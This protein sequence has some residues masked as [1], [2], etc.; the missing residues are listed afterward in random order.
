[1][2]I[3]ESSKVIRKVLLTPLLNQGLQ[4]LSLDIMLWMVIRR[5]FIASIVENTFSIT[6]GYFYV[7]YWNLIYLKNCNGGLHLKIKG[8]S[9]GGNLSSRS[10]LSITPFCFLAK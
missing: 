1:M 4:V 7:V 3:G 2:L 6:L 9:A 5:D 10:N 8:A